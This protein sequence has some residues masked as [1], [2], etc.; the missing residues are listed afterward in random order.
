MI[1]YKIYISGK[2]SGEKNYMRNFM[3]A[4][5]YLRSKGHC[6][7]VNPTTIDNSQ[8]EVWQD[9]MRADI[10]A[11]MDCNAIYMIDGWE[12]SRGAVLERSIALSLGYK[13]ILKSSFRIIV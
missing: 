6:D 10:K 8:S 12:R 4:E 5:N 11:M 2:I 1:K 7:I 9:Y 13:E 3:D